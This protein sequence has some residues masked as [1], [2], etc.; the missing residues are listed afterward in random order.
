MSFRGKFDSMV[1]A[2]DASSSGR[3]IARSRGL[4]PYGQAAS[5]SNVRGDLPEE[6]ELTKILSVGFFDGIAALRVALDV[7]KAPV[8][9]HMSVESNPQARQVVECNFPDPI[10]V[11]D[12]MAVTEDM[13]HSWAL[14]FSTVGLVLVGAGPPCQ[15]VSGLNSDRIKVHFEIN[16]ADSSS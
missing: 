4:T 10:D 13:I 8:A 7:L 16:V 11:D 9:G 12:V 5:L 2:S 15:G 1:T 14:Q 3:G 6:L